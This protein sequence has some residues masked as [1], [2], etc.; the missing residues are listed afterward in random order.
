MKIQ[1]EEDEV[2]APGT[3]HMSSYLIMSQ[4]ALPLRAFMHAGTEDGVRFFFFFGLFF[5]WGCFVI[6]VWTVYIFA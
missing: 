2:K 3:E 4:A 1:V 6:F 5:S